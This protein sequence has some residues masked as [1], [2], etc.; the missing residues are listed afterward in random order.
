MLERRIRN[1]SFGKNPFEAAYIQHLEGRLGPFNT[2]VDVVSV[3]GKRKE[4]TTY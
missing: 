3:S 4:R 2:S 1:L